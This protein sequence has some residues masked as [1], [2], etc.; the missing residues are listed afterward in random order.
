[1]RD[2]TAPAGGVRFWW[3]VVNNSSGVGVRE[4]RGGI[5]EGCAAIRAVIDAFSKNDN[6]A[7]T[8]ELMD[9]IQREP[10]VFE[11]FKAAA[12]TQGG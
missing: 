1:M 10:R 3:R 8:L 2:S 4:D 5:F 7:E 11:I 12:T 6:I 9:L